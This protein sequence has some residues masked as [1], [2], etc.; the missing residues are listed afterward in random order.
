M[1][2]LT[3]AEIPKR[4][5]AL[6]AY[7]PF[8]FSEKE[9]ATRKVAEIKKTEKR[10]HGYEDNLTDW[11]KEINRKFPEQSGAG[12]RFVKLKYAETYAKGPAKTLPK[13]DAIVH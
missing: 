7:G 6:C 3:P 11:M 9:L 4:E 8:G 1:R 2:Y 13:K 12:H 10:S 5:M